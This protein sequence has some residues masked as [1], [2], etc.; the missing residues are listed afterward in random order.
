MEG[1]PFDI[2]PVAASFYYRA[3]AF[4]LYMFLRPDEIEIISR[5]IAHLP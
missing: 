1:D 4:P 2:V 3:V 5:V